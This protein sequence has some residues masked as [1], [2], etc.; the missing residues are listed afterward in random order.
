MRTFT[1]E[2][3]NEAPFIARR[4]AAHFLAEMHLLA[5]AAPSGPILQTLEGHALDDPRRLIAN[6]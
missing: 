5:Q 2:C 6:I 1:F 3:Q 4:R